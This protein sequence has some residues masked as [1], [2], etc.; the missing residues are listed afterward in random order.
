M[1]TYLIQSLLQC[2]FKFVSTSLLNLDNTASWALVLCLIYYIPTC[3]WATLMPIWYNYYIYNTQGRPLNLTVVIAM[4]VS[5]IIIYWNKFS[6]M[7]NCPH[8]NSKP[9][10]I[11]TTVSACW[12]HR[13]SPRSATFSM[14]C[15]LG[16]CQQA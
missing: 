14:V 3:L 2:D 4:N 9:A 12:I 15:S 6:A 11:I 5:Y 10:N 7:I 16:A 1:N 13:Y 8:S